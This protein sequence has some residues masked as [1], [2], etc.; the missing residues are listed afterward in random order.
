MR[1]GGNKKHLGK[2]NIG[3]ISRKLNE[4]DEIIFF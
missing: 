2:K 3:Q 4:G 1:E